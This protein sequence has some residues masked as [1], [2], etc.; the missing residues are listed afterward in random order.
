MRLLAILVGLAVLSSACFQR[1]ADQ[2]HETLQVQYSPLSLSSDDLSVHTFTGI[3]SPRAITYD[4]VNLWIANI[5]MNIEISIGELV[6]LI[7]NLMKVDV[8][9]DSSEKRVRPENSEV[10]RLVCNNSKLLKHTSW[11]P[12]YT[13]EQGITEVI[14]WLKN[15]ENLNMYKARYYNV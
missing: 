7:A 10:E 12:K 6:E 14:E 5:G 13:L 9:I 8:T 4:G 15:P 2:L 3:S 11:K 1:G